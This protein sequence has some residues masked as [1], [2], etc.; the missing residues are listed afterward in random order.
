MA[1]LHIPSDWTK[2]CLC[3]NATTE[4]LQQADYHRF[5]NSNG[6]KTLH[7]NIPILCEFSDLPI[8]INP[9]RLDEGNLG[10]EETLKKNDAKYHPSCFLMFSNT[11]VERARKR[12]ESATEGLSNNEERTK[13]QHLNTK[14]DICFICEKEDTRENLRHASTMQ[15]GVSLKEIALTLN[16]RKLQAKLS[17]P[18]VVAQELKYH[19]H[20]YTGLRN[21]ARSLKSEERRLEKGDGNSGYA[22]AFSELLAHLHES[23]NAA[24]VEQVTVFRLADLTKLYCERLAQLGVVEPNV[25]ATRLKERILFHVP[26]VEAY[27]SGRDVI[28]AFQKDIGPVLSSDTMNYDEAILISKTAGILR[29]KMLQCSSSFNGKFDS[30]YLNSSVPPEL[31]HFVTCLAHGSGIKTQM[32]S[33]VSKADVAMAQL[34]QFNCCSK[35]KLTATNYRHST[36]REPPLPVYLG[37]SLY[38]RTRKKQLVNTLFEH[39]LSVSYDRILEISNQL[40]EAVISQYVE[41]DIVCPPQMK[42]SVFTL[43]AVDNID[44]DPKATTA[45]TSFHGTSISLFQSTARGEPRAELDVKKKI[46]KIPDL[47]ESYTKVKPA[48]LDKCPVPPLGDIPTL[49]AAPNLKPEYDWLQSVALTEVYDNTI[50]VTW[51]AHNAQQVRDLHFD[52]DMSAIM[53]LLRD[54]SNEV[55]TIKHTMDK[56][57]D[58]IN[59]LNPSQSPVLAVDQP[60]FALAK[61][62][63]WKWPQMYG[64]FVI[65]MG[66]LHIEMAALRVAGSLLKGSGWTTAIEESGIAT[67]GTAESFL[68]AANVTKT[69]RVHQVTACS[70]Y[71][72]KKKAYEASDESG[73]FDY[74]CAKREAQEPQFLYWSMVLKLE[75]II[76]AFIRSI[77]VGN[78]TG[79]IASLNA[80]M[81]YFFAND[82]THYA[83]WLSVHISDMLKLPE[84]NPSVNEEFAAGKFVIHKTK[85]LFSA[86]GVDQAHEQN[87][88]LIKGDGGAV[89]ITENESALL[90]WM[91][92]GP[93]ICR[94]VGEYDDVSKSRQHTNTSHHEHTPSVQRAFLKDVQSLCKTI[95]EFGNP[96]LDETSS[97]LLTLDSKDVMDND[98]VDALKNYIPE[99][100]KQFEKF[101]SNLEN[102]CLTMKRNNFKIFDR[103]KTKTAKKLGNAVKQ[104]CNLFANLFISCQTRQVDL[105]EFFRYENTNFPASISS[106]GDLY[107]GTKSELMTCLEKHVEVSVDEPETDALFIDG[108]HLAHV[109]RPK[110]LTFKD[111]AEHDFVEKINKYA[112]RYK[113][114]DVVFDTYNSQ[115]LKSFTRLQ[116]GRGSRRRV[117]ERGKVPQ[118]WPSF[119]QNEENKKELYVFLAHKLKQATGGLVFATAMAS[120]VSNREDEVNHM[121]EDMTDCL[122]EEADTRIF[123]HVMNAVKQSCITKAA[124]LANDIDVVVIA[125]ATF[126]VLKRSG[127][128]HL[129]VAYGVGKN[130]RWLPVHSL[131]SKLEEKA[132]GLLFFHA[133]TGCDTVSAFKGKGKKSCFQT[134]D[135]FPQANDTFRQLS[136]PCVDITEDQMRV[137]E[138]FV[139]LLYDRSSSEM[140]VN[141]ARKIMFA[142]K[143]RSYDAIPPTREA[144][145]QHVRRATYQAGHIWGQALQAKPALPLP[146]TWGWKVDDDGTLTIH[147]T[148]L[149]AV[150]EQCQALKKC[151]CKTE[152]GG[153]CTCKKSALPCTSLCAC[154]CIL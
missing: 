86:I 84:A 77:R 71:Q 130:K 12:K 20:C 72:L 90:R 63:Q 113:R 75:V 9:A 127:L 4:R 136:S 150:A 119:L 133:V 132:C 18:D 24:G 120:C 146:I 81:P 125:V 91:V 31:Q 85:R 38:S 100:T 95:D 40:G 50:N 116:R 37:L 139:V 97:E 17:G 10:I 118:N 82:S 39:G 23:R 137:I 83:R 25:N 15:I 129:W 121:M 62:I 41:D 57:K 47:P 26:E 138:Q 117:T 19:L 21:K 109:I 48:F 74:W 96:F 67:S 73:N 2:C 51:S 78:F 70:L 135:I 107:R 92:S 122:H 148:D 99:G 76:C 1:S 27:K 94:L 103:P 34:L 89:G 33:G 7:K 128:D 3:Q 141:K 6:Y 153:R 22:F 112:E 101:I 65:L 59:H 152:C 44:H 14:E 115:S 35:K 61:Q 79:Y 151:Q 106:S 108:A 102:I 87:N 140:S 104:D 45:R 66:S 5:P 111:Y 80:L 11:K 68:S 49:P 29:K 32:E 145:I 149:R 69:R 58:V 56:V 134:W 124:I 144:L 105:E 46:K 123:V 88:A 30:Q 142:E 55:S 36:K 53:P 93:E 54:H 114:T 98:A 64:N 13:R 147:W 28:I 42:C 110:H 52:V 16:D 43:A 154:P 143:N 60:L 8:P 126:P 131:V